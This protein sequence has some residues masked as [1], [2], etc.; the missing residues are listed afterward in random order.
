M[1]G[2]VVLLLEPGIACSATR[3]RHALARLVTTLEAASQSGAQSPHTR[4]VFE[5]FLTGLADL[6]TPLPVAAE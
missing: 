3:R 4:Q 5:L 2:L 1:L 6:L